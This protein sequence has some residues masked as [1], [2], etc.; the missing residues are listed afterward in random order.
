MSGKRNENVDELVETVSKGL[1]DS[2]TVKVD[3]T[4]DSKLPQ[5]P[6]YSGKNES[7]VMILTDADGK[8]HEQITDKFPATIQDSSGAIYEVDE[9]GNVTQDGKN[10]KSDNLDEIIVSTTDLQSDLDYYFT[11][12]ND[13]IAL[14][15]Q[16]LD[17]AKN[18]GQFEFKL[19]RKGSTINLDSI[20]IVTNSDTLRNTDIVKTNLLNNLFIQ[21]KEKEDTLVYLDILTHNSPH[22]EFKTLSSY[23]GEFGF[24]DG[25]VFTSETTPP[26]SIT[27]MYD[28]IRVTDGSHIYNTFITLAPTQNINLKLSINNSILGDSIILNSNDARILA[29]FNPI[30]STI[31]IRNNNFMSIDF[32]DHALI[33][34]YRI[35]KNGIQQQSKIGRCQIISMP[36]INIDVQLVY[37]VSDTTQAQTKVGADSL[38]VNINALRDRL[39]NHSF[40]QG[41][42]Q[43]TVHNTPWVIKDNLDSLTRTNMGDAYDSIRVY[44]Q[45]TKGINVTSGFRPTVIYAIMT[46]PIFPTATSGHY[47]GGGVMGKNNLLKIIPKPSFVRLHCAEA[48]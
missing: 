5:I 21:V 27:G 29:T 42:F 2:D 14:F 45:K 3:F 33:D 34:I 46:E 30:D 16:R 20:Y 19:H 35:N 48:G 36:T 6:I 32:K 47:L 40:N 18:N 38:N 12:E 7:F 43:F 28:T 11:F 15:N 25:S 37:F 41:F 17:L 23:N 26:K 10:S 8:T 9:Q 39:N 44:L 22:I 4:I 13:T 31:N 1:G 24:D